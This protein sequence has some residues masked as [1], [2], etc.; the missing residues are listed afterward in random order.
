[1]FFVLAGN[2]LSNTKPVNSVILTI[3][4]TLFSNSLYVHG[5]RY[6]KSLQ[7]RFVVPFSGSLSSEVY[8]HSP[9]SWLY[10]LPLVAP[11][12]KT[13]KFPVRILVTLCQHPSNGGCPVNK[14]TKSDNSS[15]TNC[16][17][18]IFVALQNLP[19]FTLQSLLSEK[20]CMCVCVC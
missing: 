19:L 4:L 11:A 12:G 18:K 14:G 1:M 6:G 8:P 3:Q 17:L 9:V 15:L 5:S 13:P 10:L 20:K 2:L 16:S 7:T